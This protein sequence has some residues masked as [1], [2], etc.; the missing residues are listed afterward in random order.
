MK[1]KQLWKYKAYWTRDLPLQ[2]HTTPVDTC[3]P[4]RW[5]TR[6]RLSQKEDSLKAVKQLVS[7]EMFWSIMTLMKMVIIQCNA[8]E[9]GFG[10]T[11]LQHRQLVAYASRALSQKEYRYT[12]IEKEWLSILFACE[13]FD[14]SI[15][16][17]D[18]CCSSI[19]PPTVGRDI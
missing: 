12:Q 4:L 18:N 6:H 9:V 15:Y 8:P 10:E 1:W 3:E 5:L 14:Q 16:D 19:R 13:H 17:R 2:V 7:T 11:L